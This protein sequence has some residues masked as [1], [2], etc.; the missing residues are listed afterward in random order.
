MEGEIQN[1]LYKHMKWKSQ[2]KDLQIKSLK[3]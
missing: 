3:P 2:K 1:C